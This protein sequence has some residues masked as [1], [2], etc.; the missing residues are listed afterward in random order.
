M[1]SNAH[2]GGVVPYSAVPRKL[3]SDSGQEFTWQV[4]EELIKALGIQRVLTSPYHPEGNVINEQSHRIMNNMLHTLL[5]D[6][7]PAPHRVNKI[8]ALML[9]LNF[10]P[11][12]PHWYST[13]MIATG[14]ENTLLPD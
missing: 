12:Q 13:S 6:G 2:L 9:T 8:L 11:H 5:Y 1:V 14:Q 10:M 7:T 4:W 3:F